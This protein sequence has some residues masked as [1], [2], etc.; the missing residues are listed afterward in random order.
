MAR[1]DDP[2]DVHVLSVAAVPL[3][4]RVVPVAGVFFLFFFNIIK[5]FPY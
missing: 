4:P 2:L 5:V 1:L 3:I